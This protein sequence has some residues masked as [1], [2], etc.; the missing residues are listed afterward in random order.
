M[1]EEK[2]LIRKAMMADA[3]V[4]AAI[5]NKS[6]QAAYREI[7]PA[8]ELRRH[9][10]M[11]RRYRKMRELLNQPEPGLYLA[12]LRQQPCG[13]VMLGPSRDEDLADYGE[14]IAFYILPE[15][16][17]QGVAQQLMDFVLKRLKEQGYS[18]ILLWVLKN[19][20]RAR[21]FYEISGFSSDGR[22]RAEQFSNAPLTLRYRL[23]LAE[24]QAEQG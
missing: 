7:I 3:R 24:R 8:A 15:F 20:A 23:N 1:A 16:W 5:L 13:M 10:T 18:H 11:E 2:L 14:I 22:S 12:T 21:R 19:N 17:G 9:T 6:W 4:L